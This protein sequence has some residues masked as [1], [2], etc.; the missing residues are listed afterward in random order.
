MQTITQSDTCQEKVGR[1]LSRINSIY[2]MYISQGSWNRL[3]FKMFSSSIK[4]IMYRR[5]TGCFPSIPNKLNETIQQ[6]E[7]R[8]S[9]RPWPP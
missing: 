9:R 1:A 7:T 5:K 4:V 2:N 6:T 3:Y 8:Q